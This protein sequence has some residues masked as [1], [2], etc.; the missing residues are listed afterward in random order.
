MLADLGY[1][2]WLGNARGNHYSRH[3]EFHNPDKHKAKFWNFSWHEIGTIDLPAMIDYV[4]AKSG[5]EKLHYIGHSQGTT[6]FYVMCSEKPEYN[7]KIKAMFSLAPVAYMKNIISPLML[8]QVKFLNMINVS[9][10]SV[11]LKS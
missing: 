2:V 6:V 8:I 11:T 1:D 5:Q 10:L 4:L 3:N 7:D 9:Y